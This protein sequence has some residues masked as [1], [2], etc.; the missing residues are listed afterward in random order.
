MHKS[1][2]DTRNFNKVQK[3]NQYKVTTDKDNLTYIDSARDTVGIGVDAWVIEEVC[4]MTITISGYDNH[5]II[6]QKTRIGNGVTDK[7][8]PDG[9]TVLN[10]LSE[11]TLLGENANNLVSTLQLQEN[12]VDIDD[13]PKLHGRKSFF[14][15]DGIIVTLTLTKGMMT[16]NIRNPQKFEFNSCEVIEI[17]KYEIWNLH[18]YSEDPMN[19]NDY[20]QLFSEFD[21]KRSVNMNQLP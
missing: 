10:R 11:A 16:L 18:L 2:E 6:Q 7:T 21:D 15:K 9:E 1:I 4:D 19:E 17:N 13:R 14:D 5:H 3:K 12:F 8:L 20:S